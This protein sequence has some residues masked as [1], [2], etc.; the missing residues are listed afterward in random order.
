MTADTVKG[1][2]AARRILS[3]IAL[4]FKDLIFELLRRI[5]SLYELVEN[6]SSFH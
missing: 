2:L 1:H 6:I 3:L 5:C 4:E